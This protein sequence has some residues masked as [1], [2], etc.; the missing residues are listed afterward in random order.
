MLMGDQS[1]FEE[2]ELPPEEDP[3]W[4]PQVTCPSCGLQQTRL[5]SMRHEASLYRCE[6]CS[7]EFEVD[8]GIG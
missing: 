3:I 2:G 1:Y 6:V 5:L 8:E 7:V 4:R